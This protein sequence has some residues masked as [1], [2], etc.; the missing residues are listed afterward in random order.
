MSFSIVA[1]CHSDTLHIY[2]SV[3][4]IPRNTYPV[5]NDSLSSGASVGSHL[6]DNNPVQMTA[7]I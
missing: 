1:S 7:E 5:Y 2:I 6:F 3:Y 4:W